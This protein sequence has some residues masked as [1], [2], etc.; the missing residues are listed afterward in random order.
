MESGQFQFFLNPDDLDLQ[1]LANDIESI[2]VTQADGATRRLDSVRHGL[3]IAHEHP[4]V[5]RMSEDLG[6]ICAVFQDS[7]HYTL[8]LSGVALSPGDRLELTY[9]HT[10]YT[11]MIEV[12]EQEEGRAII[13]PPRIIR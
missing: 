10:S 9:R 13:R 6:A 11:V 5:D 7:N 2:T 4:P 1:A 12:I 8:T 3:S